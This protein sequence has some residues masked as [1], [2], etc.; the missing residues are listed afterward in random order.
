M[1]EHEV[2]SYAEFLQNQVNDFHFEDWFPEEGFI[3]VEIYM[4]LKNKFD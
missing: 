2:M 3:D 4:K 1:T